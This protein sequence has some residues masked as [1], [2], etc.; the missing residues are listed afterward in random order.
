MIRK[1]LDYSLSISMRDTPQ[2]PILAIS[3]HLC[4]IITQID[5][6]EQEIKGEPNKAEKV[7]IWISKSLQSR[8]TIAQL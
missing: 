2:P 1:Q 3:L 8:I 7:M 6:S 5:R 4:K